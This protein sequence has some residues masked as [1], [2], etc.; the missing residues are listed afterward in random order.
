VSILPS[1]S[2]HFPALIGKT[3]WSDGRNITPKGLE[4][5]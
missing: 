5:Q 2:S 4:I 1:P 3:D